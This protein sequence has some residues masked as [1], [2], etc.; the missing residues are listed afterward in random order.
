MSRLD[1][2]IDEFL[3]EVR[4]GIDF[5]ESAGGIALVRGAAI[6]HAETY[7]DL[8][9]STLEQR[10]AARRGR[11]TRRSKKRRLARLRSW[12]LRQKLP[13]GSR[14]PNPYEVLADKSLWVPP[15]QYT[16]RDHTS[17]PKNTWIEYVSAGKGTSDEFVRALTLLFKKRGYKYDDRGFHDLSDKEF[18]E[19][20]ET[21]RIPPAAE[22]LREQVKQE[23]E[24]RVR[25]V[26]D[27]KQGSLRTALEAKL[28]AAL[29]REKNSGIA[30]P[31]Q[32]K[33]AELEQVVQGF[34]RSAG[35]PDDT[36]K[37]WQKELK[38]ILNKVIQPA[39]FE[40]RM[41]TRCS[42]CDAAYPPRKAKVR[43]LAYRAAV[44]NLRVSEG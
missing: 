21:V 10:R 12:V 39:R 9:E 44:N 37:R 36:V 32:V 15:G 26:E 31:C 22:D 13:D 30:E 24:R 3:K 35:L 33:E 1:S 19:F 6:L 17:D 11:R 16:G 27:R 43:E 40:N 18:Q 38:G 28:K 7:V 25:E 29:K 20:L 42:W 34:G 8:H 4:V 2:H 41:R 23:I 14:L 5:G